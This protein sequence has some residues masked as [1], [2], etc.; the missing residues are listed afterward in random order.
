DAKRSDLVTSHRGPTK[1]SNWV[2]PGRLMA[3]DRSSLDSEETLRAI[4][5][6]GVTTVVCLQTRQETSAAVDYRKKA[7]ALNPRVAFV[8]QPIPD[9][10]VTDDAMVEELVSQL[11]ERL[12]AG[13]V[14]YVHCRGGHGRTGTICAILLGRMYKLSAAEAMARTQVY[15]DVRQQPVFAAEGYQETKDGSSCVIL[16][17]SQRQQVVRLLRGEAAGPALDRASSAAYGP[18]A[19]KYPVE[20]MVEWQGLPQSLLECILTGPMAVR[21]AL[22]HDPEPFRDPQPGTV[23]PEDAALSTGWQKQQ[24]Y[25]QRE[26]DGR[27]WRLW[28]G[29]WSASPKGSGG[30]GSRPRYDQMP[31][32]SDSTAG[33]AADTDPERAGRGEFMKEIQRIVTTARKADGRVRRL[34]DERSRREAQWKEFERKSRSDF[35]EEKHK[36]VADLQKL[37]DDI[38]AAKKQGVDAST[39]VQQLVATGMRAREAP[40]SAEAP[41][42]WDT[43]LTAEGAEAPSGFLQD[44][45]AA[46]ERARGN[47]PPLPRE[48][49]GRF[50]NPTDAARV[51]AATLAALPP[52][53]GLEQLTGHTGP[54]IAAT[55][56]AP[57]P[58]A[59]SEGAG[60]LLGARLGDVEMRP[61][62][63]T[64][65]PSSVKT[66][67]APFPPASP[68]TRTAPTEEAPEPPD[69]RHL[70]PMHPG[71][72]D[73]AL[74]RVP[75]AEEPPR[76]EDELEGSALNPFRLSPALHAPP[77]LPH[78]SAAGQE[79]AN[80]ARPVPIVPD[81]DE[82]PRTWDLFSSSGSPGFWSCD[83]EQLPSPRLPLGLKLVP[84][85]GWFLLVGSVDFVLC[86]VVSL[87]CTALR[88]YL[89]LLV[90]AALLS[91]YPFLRHPSCSTGLVL[92]PGIASAFTPA[93]GIQALL[94][95][96]FQFEAGAQATCAE[97]VNSD[98]LEVDAH[99]L[100][101]DD[102]D[103]PPVSGFRFVSAPLPGTMPTTFNMPPA[104]GVTIH[105]PRFMPTFFGLQ[106]PD[107][108]S[109]QDVLHAAVSLG[110][111]P[112]PALDTVIPVTNQRFDTAMSFLAYPSCISMLDPPHCAVILDLTRVGGHYHAAA[113]PCA[114]SRHALF[115]HIETLIWHDTC[116]V[117]VW[118]DGAEFPASHGLLAFAHGSVLTVL[119]RGHRPSRFVA[120]SDILR[121]PTAWGPFEQSPSPRRQVGE[122]FVNSRGVVKLRYNLLSP[123]SPESSIRRALDLGPLDFLMHTEQHMRLDVHGDYCHSVFAG[124]SSARPWLLDMRLIGHS[125]R[126]FF[127]GAEPSVDYV[128]QCEPSI[129][130]L[131]ARLR[132]HCTAPADSGSPYLPVVEVSLLPL[133][134]YAHAAL[135]ERLRTYEPTGRPVDEGLDSQTIH[136]TADS[137]RECKSPS[138][139]TPSLRQAA[140]SEAVAAHAG[141]L[142]A[143]FLRIGEAPPVQALVLPDDDGDDGVR[144]PPVQYTEVAEL[145]GT[146]AASVRIVAADPVP[147]DVAC[148]GFHCRHVFGVSFLEDNDL[149]QGDAKPCVSFIDCRLLLQGWSLECSESGQIDHAELVDWLDTF[150]PPDWQPQLLNV[151]VD[152][153][154]VQSSHGGVI[155][156]E[157]VPLTTSEE[158]PDHTGSDGPPQHDAGPDADDPEDDS[159]S[160]D[161]SSDSADDA[162]AQV[163]SARPCLRH[164]DRSRSPRRGGGNATSCALT[165]PGTHQHGRAL[166]CVLLALVVLLQQNAR[167]RV[168][169]WLLA[170]SR[171]AVADGRLAFTSVLLLALL[172][173][174]SAAHLSP[175][176]FAAPPAVLALALLCLLDW[177][178]DL[179]TSVY[180]CLR[181][182]VEPSPVSVG[183]RVQ[184]AVLRYFAPHL[185]AP[186]RYSP[187]PNALW[188]V[189]DAP[190]DAED[191]DT[192]EQV[193]DVPFFVLALGFS[194]ERLIV[195][196]RLPATPAEV[197]LGVQAERSRE[198]V[199][200]FPRLVAANPQPIPGVGVLLSCPAWH[201][202]V[203]NSSAFVCVDT[204]QIDG[205]VFVA[206]VPNYMHR[207]QLVAVANLPPR[208]AVDVYVGASSAP[209][210]EQ[211]WC[212]LVTGDAISFCPEG[213]PR[214]AAL[215]FDQLL[216]PHQVWCD[217]PVLPGQGATNSYCLVHDEGT[218]LHIADY[219]VPTTY[220]AQIAAAL[221]VAERGLQLCPAQPRVENAC[222]D[223]VVCRAVLAVRDAGLSMQSPS[224]GVILD[225][226]FLLL[227]W[228]V[229]NAVRSQVD[230][231]ALLA[232]LRAEAPLGWSVALRG[233]APDV[234]QL[235]VFPGQVLTVV[236]KPEVSPPA[237]L[238]AVEPSDSGVA[239]GALAGSG[240]A[241]PLPGSSADAPGNQSES[242]APTPVQSEDPASHA[243]ASG[244]PLHTDNEEEPAELHFLILTPEYA[245]EHVSVQTRLPLTIVESIALVAARRADDRQSLFPRL[246]A[247][248]VQPALPAACVLALPSWDSVGVPIVI[249]SYVP[250]LRVFAQ[251]VPTV[252]D[253]D[254]VLRLAQIG[255]HQQA[256]VFVSDTPWPIEHG[257]PF[258]VDVGDLVMILP[259]E[260]PVIPPLRLRTMLAS[261]AGWHTDP[262]LPIPEA[263]ALW[264]VTQQ[265]PIRFVAP[266][267]PRPPVR[268]DVAQLLGLCEHE[269]H[270]IPADP[271]I[272]DHSRGGLASRQV[273]IAA[274]AAAGEDTPFVL[275][276]RPVLLYIDWDRA[277]QGQVD[278]AR[279]CERHRP[280]CPPGYFIRVRGGIA[281]GDVA[282][283]Y[284]RVLPGQVITVEFWPRRDLSL[285]GI[286][287][288]LPGAAGNVSDED[289][290]DSPGPVAASASSSDSR[291]RHDA[292]T[293]GTRH[294]GAPSAGVDIRVH[295][296]VRLV[297]GRLGMWSVGI[298]Q[299]AF[300]DGDQCLTPACLHFVTSV[301]L[302]WANSLRSPSFDLVRT[303]LRATLWCTLHL[304]AFVHKFARY[305]AGRHF[306]VCILLV[307][308]FMPSFAVG[309]QI[310]N[311]AADEAPARCARPPRPSDLDSGHATASAEPLR[312]RR[313]ATPC[314][315]SET[316]EFLTLSR[317]AFSSSELSR[318]T[319]SLALPLDATPL[320]T[321]LEESRDSDPHRAY[322]ETRV[323]VETLSEHFGAS[324][325]VSLPDCRPTQISLSALLDVPAAVGTSCLPREQVQWYNLEDNACATPLTRDLIADLCRFCPIS[326]IGAL[327]PS[328]EGPDRFRHWV[329]SGN[330]GF[331]PSDALSLCLTSDGSYSP[332]SGAAG[333]GVV[334]SV[335]TPDFPSVPG[336]FIGAVCGATDAIWQFGGDDAGPVNAYASELVGLLWAAV[337]AYQCKFRGSVAFF[338]D[339]LAALGAADST[340]ACPSNSVAR[341]CQDLHQG[342]A[343]SEWGPPRYAHVRGHSGDPANELADAVAGSGAIGGGVNPFSL[344]FRD[345]FAADAF[346]WVPHFCWS[347]R[348]PAEG[349]CLKDGTLTWSR[350]EP[351]LLLDP[352]DVLSPFTR[353]FPGTSGPKASNISS[354]RIVVATFNTLS[355]V[356]TGQD[357]GRGAGLYG[358]TGRV[359]LLDGALHK[360]GVFLAGLQETRT[361]E[362]RGQSTHF[363]RYSSG[364]HE[365]RVLGVELW[366]ANGSP[367]PSHTVV[368]LH[369]DPTRLCARV[370]F[371]EVQTCVLVAH[372]LHAGHSY[373]DRSAWWAD[374]EALCSRI[375]FDERW[376]LLIDANC[377]VEALARCMRIPLMMS[378]KSF[379]PCCG[380]VRHGCLAHL[381]IPFMGMVEHLFK[382]GHVA[383]EI[384][385]GHAIIDHFAVLVTVE[386]RTA[387]ARP[388]R[389]APRIDMQAIVRPENAATI[390]RICSAV[391]PI[392]WQI[393]VHD[394]S[395]VVV[396]ALYRGLADAFP[397]KGRRLGKHFLSDET[398]TV[399]QHTSVLR[400]ALRWRLLAYRA[401]LTRCAFTAWTRRLAFTDVFVGRWLHQ[402]RL[403]IAGS[404]ARLSLMGKE[405]RRLCRR[406][407]AAYFSS[408][409]EE[410]ESAPPGQIH[411][412][413]KKVLRPKKFRR[414]GAQPLPRLVRP[415]GSLCATAEQVS[416]EWR[417]HFA[418]LE[419]GQVVA[420]DNL[421]QACVARQRAAGSSS[422]LPAEELPSFG[423]LVRALK[424]M[425]PFRAAGPD[426]VP[427]SICARFALPIARLLWPILLKGALMSTEALA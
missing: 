12:A 49:G 206:Q 418:A 46:A 163:S 122:A 8:E 263:D 392:D 415:D 41:D 336:V 388:R 384:S 248:P 159:E 411:V 48:G 2:V 47:G 14:L 258:H 158:P 92:A 60:A 215:T 356:E 256:R 44:A 127:G 216:S 397:L 13:E 318:D 167:R 106:V 423:D 76:F 348:F 330:L 344:D 410:A 194:G 236:L 70:A 317:S 79:T 337:V 148:H 187:S 357:T 56:G 405:V 4:F 238:T 85:F 7:K 271:S 252:L 53:V 355:I 313:V 28:Q 88:D 151:L 386:L 353:A 297:F 31:L 201:S 380:N 196:L 64:L 195:P 243:V 21:P 26:V 164:Q 244:E 422:S 178:R 352:V 255:G 94:L 285:A 219:G 120:P 393:S 326:Q 240:D 137:I 408:L 269:L 334:L 302:Q 170:F 58:P 284:R 193:V 376:I 305:A 308:A 218:V 23:T 333:W 389:S 5:S 278:V 300:L 379:M 82:V 372:A 173:C 116:E 399:H 366:V 67:D 91:R 59:F 99:P 327:P 157:Y 311:I 265:A 342:L 176:S 222:L 168:L 37:E 246:I 261:A 257:A 383:P 403:S 351:P 301:L 19:S 267:P 371:A 73:P 341:A 81:D 115:E 340:C 38:E 35:L 154:L 204:A 396:D 310:F 223:G 101:P 335:T 172:P 266:P 373:A 121:P 395:A 93:L 321:L 228:R 253:A 234:V 286:D 402:L 343:F 280:R 247:V 11:L 185:G 406:D 61:A 181:L 315:A 306:A 227:G 24:Q 184:L 153:G 417:R 374:T 381:L 250:P 188:I 349:P 362:G 224:V 293:G 179:C 78:A 146:T 377:K 338:C 365:R 345:W 32:P 124:P 421:V 87:S 134:D 419:G 55:H 424:G 141:I 220:R 186:W 231:V 103:A 131:K 149:T 108:A 420:Q 323:L 86:I 273:F 319:A 283:H 117:E 320:R 63:S 191:T 202:D 347:V 367:W 203:R 254:G 275:D 189:D 425:Q 15:H 387:A 324:L 272:R 34:M 114:L 9:Q 190:S 281:D 10:E 100:R 71:Q 229:L 394:H 212:N 66:S 74:R 249:V 294:D 126:A 96:F 27:P 132:L 304:S 155:V 166:V 39:E 361:P 143:P 414:G 209:L 213:E 33:R 368:V 156:A 233:I 239:D 369:S 69:R 401:A 325:V 129:A 51:L 358:C 400:H 416:D 230:C 142:P 295:S 314:R 226:R 77:G 177:Y 133:E 83:W 16:F 75:T 270:F 192:D 90:G 217:S 150:S 276:L 200:H 107:G 298:S 309:V 118:V 426:L 339:N 182:L 175:L 6:S 332:S 119:L 135:P 299:D 292:G 136:P 104:L 138:E 360:A 95:C 36:Y 207:H 54:C 364:C 80:G 214:V 279:L 370:V 385:A 125:V 290:S 251:C 235:D 147:A 232:D 57:T 17:P 123:Y 25:G 289:Y 1:R 30:A 210:D 50:L 128:V 18:G 29:A 208:L 359:A 312:L 72:R 111:L 174:A 328:L 260:H 62:Y 211:A 45:L 130:P 390:R 161:L 316:T 52:G 165:A 139:A 398:A 68:S 363:A 382:N 225:L 282:N 322:F 197:A 391:P 110:K 287:V 105:A 404:S 198:Q 102:L 171:G 112:H 242:S 65:S 268:R 20:K 98:A 183:G 109:V 22:R 205:R 329:S 160:S 162:D 407:R 140:A 277:P 221:G 144:L 113:L 262:V 307:L 296:L 288:D 42:D 259:P 180:W 245:G 84:V 346:R 43:L 291:T 237:W 274:P 264:I 303:F 40:L 427:P 97:P 3:G 241:P 375:G 331:F 412:A 350:I 354:V 89:G 145:C 378:G 413:I 169:M 409:A 152:N 199:W